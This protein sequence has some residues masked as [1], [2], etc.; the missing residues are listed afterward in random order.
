MLTAAPKTRRRRRRRHKRSV[1]VNNTADSN[2]VDVDDDESVDDKFEY[3]ENSRHFSPRVN[4]KF[5]NEDVEIE[6]AML[7]K[8][9][10]R[11]SE[12]ALKKDR[13]IEFFTSNVSNG[14]V[15]QITV[16]KDDE[17]IEI[18]P[19]PEPTQENYQEGPQTALS[20]LNDELEF[21]AVVIPFNR[22]AMISYDEQQFYLPELNLPKQLPD[23][24]ESS[25]GEAN[26]IRNFV[27]EGHFERSKPNISGTNRALFINRL[28]EEGAL[29]WF[30]FN[31]KE[32]KHIFDLTLSRRLIKTFCAEKFHPIDFPPTSILLDYDAFQDRIL[33]I[34]LKHIYFDV[35][36]TF[37]DEQ[38]LA[39]EIESLFDEFIAIKQSN[40]LQRIDTKLNILRKLLETISRGNKSKTQKQMTF[41]SLQ[42]HRDELKELR[43]T[44]HK[45]S[46][47]YREITKTILEKWVELK[48]IREAATEQSTSLKLKIMVHEPDVEQDKQEWSERFE[49]EH[50]E[51]ME[52]A[53]DLY[54]KQKA[55]RKKN[56]KRG[57]RTDID[58][59]N[60]D[61]HIEIV[62]PNAKDIEK[63]LMDIFSN[64]MRPPGEKIIDF[65]LE[66]IST[67]TIKSPP[68]YIVRLILDDGQLEFPDSTKLNSIGQANINAVFSI[69][70][71]T[72]VSNKLTFQVK[73]KKILFIFFFLK[74]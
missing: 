8:H 5:I 21:E 53:M 10:T 6:T 15:E 64:S 40:I 47:R 1:A 35:H 9:L 3:N 20:Y 45:E 66:N 7:L 58:M 73:S 12:F 16:S 42:N 36:P 39:R 55:I 70:F 61:E 54:K 30:D 29:Q 25:A 26:Y 24:I 33:K 72:K 11:D 22:N 18:M 56:E 65:E 17:H 59:Q 51:M 71:T 34:H 68:K 4:A 46:S 38:K 2:N 23:D 31:K 62:K 37:N 67:T 49:N 19:S 13:A 28:I 74:N 69:K 57:S 52:E 48:K 60:E 43:E 50:S 14:R 27:A 63:Q 44:W 32:I 41:D